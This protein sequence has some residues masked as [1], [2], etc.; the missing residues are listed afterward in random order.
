MKSSH[1]LWGKP[2]NPQN[3]RID[4][5]V[6]SE[7]EI[8]LAME[9][10]ETFLVPSIDHVEKLFNDQGQKSAAELTNEFCKH[11]AIIRNCLLGSTCL[12]GEDGI[13]PDKNID[14]TKSSSG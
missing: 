9:L 10:L 6:P 7:K 12:I 2:G 14:E 1:R 11:L 13:D 5:H 8:D 4:W 3:L